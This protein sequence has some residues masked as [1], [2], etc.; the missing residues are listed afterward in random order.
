MEFKASVQAASSAF[1]YSDQDTKHWEGYTHYEG[2][3]R[4]KHV[5]V[6][7]NSNSLFEVIKAAIQNSG[8]TYPY[9]CPLECRDGLRAWRLD[10]SDGMRRMQAFFD[11]TPQAI[12]LRRASLA[13]LKRYWRLAGVTAGP[14]GPG[15]QPGV[16][17]AVAHRA[18]KYYDEVCANRHILVLNA[19]RWFVF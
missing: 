9:R 1:G 12:A 13:T 18:C 14:D 7:K 15:V 17:E 8:N 19:Y 4:R 3:L 2:P 10:K 6:H 11:N 16:A 5:L